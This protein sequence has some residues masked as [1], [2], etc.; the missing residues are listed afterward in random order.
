LDGFNECFNSQA[1]HV[2]RSD[3]QLKSMWKNMKARTK[4]QSCY[5][6]RERCWTGGGS[7]KIFIDL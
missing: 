7:C 3:D 6:R 5:Q 1:T 4:K 2:R